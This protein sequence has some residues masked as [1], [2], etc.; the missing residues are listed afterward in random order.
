MAV[1]L[2]KALGDDADDLADALWHVVH[3]ELDGVLPHGLEDIML[4]AAD[5]RDGEVGIDRLGELAPLLKGACRGD[6]GVHALLCCFASHEGGLLL[7]EP[8]HLALGV[9]VGCG[10]GVRAGAG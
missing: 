4:L 3:G 2:D 8:R 6:E 1:D 7:S 10:L 5:R 9:G